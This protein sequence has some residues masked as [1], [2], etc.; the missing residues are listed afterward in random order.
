MIAGLMI[1]VALLSMSGFL[2]SKDIFR[3]TDE[4]GDTHYANEVPKKYR[5]I[6]RKIDPAD[7]GL[8]IVD[9]NKD[10]SMSRSAPVVSRFPVSSLDREDTQSVAFI[11]PDSVGSSG[12][13]GLGRLPVPAP[14]ILGESGML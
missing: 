9:A 12:E 13:E 3:W 5:G 10:A 1:V 11:P 2:Q 8:S 7:V 14:A 6:A 4:Q